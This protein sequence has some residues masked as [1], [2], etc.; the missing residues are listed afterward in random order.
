LPS[1]AAS[2]KETKGHDFSAK[3]QVSPLPVIWRDGRGSDDTLRLFEGTP[4]TPDFKK[5]RKRIVE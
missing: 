2:G 3:N 5:L 1:C 4:A